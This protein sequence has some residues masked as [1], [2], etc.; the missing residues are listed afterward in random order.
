MHKPTA[1]TLSLTSLMTSWVVFKTIGTNF[2]E[3]KLDNIL[4]VLKSGI[5]FFFS[6]QPR[7]NGAFK[8]KNKLIKNTL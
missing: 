2:L 6:F 5:Y 8:M 7:E 3:S 1:N 4:G